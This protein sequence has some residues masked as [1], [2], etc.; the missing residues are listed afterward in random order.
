MAVLP[1]L[2]HRV[3]IQGKD[4]DGNQIGTYSPEYMKLRTGDYGNS[5]RY[6][7]G[8]K[9]GQAKDAGKYTRGDKKGMARNRYNR[10]PDTKVIL[11]LTRQM[12][13]D[14]T[15][16]PTENGYGIGYLNS[17]NYQ[18]AIWC[19]ETYKKKILTKLTNGELEL[20]FS[21]AQTFV[22]EYLKTI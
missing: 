20:A 9:K 17:L 14:M 11:S 22:P 16:I 10:L 1:E 12:E 21:T 3:H 7:R 8:A 6:G 19:E 2:K 18:K 15:I 5:S 13:N 4:S